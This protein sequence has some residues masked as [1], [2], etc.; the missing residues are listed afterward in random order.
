M[1]RVTV[2]CFLVLVQCHSFPVYDQGQLV[3][4]RLLEGRSRLNLHIGPYKVTISPWATEGHGRAQ[5]GRICMNARPHRGWI[6]P[7][8]GWISLYINM[9][10]GSGEEEREGKGRE[11]NP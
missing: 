9:W 11:P 4:A 2:S 10:G 3:G 5:K 7:H 1:T 8:R 6:W